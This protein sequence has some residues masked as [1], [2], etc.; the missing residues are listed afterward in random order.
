LC[1]IKTAM[2]DILR[3]Q[4]FPPIKAFRFQWSRALNHWR[5]V[6]KSSNIKRTPQRSAIINQSNTVVCHK[7]N[8]NTVKFPWNYLHGAP[9]Q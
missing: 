9:Q 1:K 6:P 5:K 3:I 8:K 7:Q 2:V 4:H